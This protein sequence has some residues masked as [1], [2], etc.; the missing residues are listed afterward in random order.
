VWQP[1]TC[2]EDGYGPSLLRL[3]QLTRKVDFAAVFASYPNGMG[4]GGPYPAGVTRLAQAGT[5]CA[6]AGAKAECEAKAMEV[7]KPSNACVMQGACVSFLV[8]TAGDEVT[9][10]EERSALLSLLGPIDKAEKAMLVALYDGAFDGRPFACVLPGAIPA[11]GPGQTLSQTLATGDGFDVQTTWDSCGGGIFTQTV[12]VAADGTLTTDSKTKVGESRCMVGRRP[13]GLRAAACLPQATRLGAFLAGA[14]RLEAASVFAFERLARELGA[15]GAPAE[16]QAE[17]LRSALDEVRHAR[18]M[19]ALARRFGGEL[20]APEVAALPVRSR[21]A[22][23]LENAIEGCVRETYGALLA[24]HQAQTARD[25]ELRAALRGIADDELRH[26]LLAHTVAEW[27]EPQLSASERE[28]LAG[29]RRAALIQ[30][31]AEL[32][33]GLVPAELGLLGWP[34]RAVAAELIQRLGQALGV[35]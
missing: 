33:T 30:L 16:L 23:A 5:Q 17:A 11:L 34:S 10:S 9:R 3:D 6:T 32:D 8:T 14:A 31:V 20:L 4:Q 26:A 22:I 24:E 18:V 13:A 12:H 7:A 2:G 25:P 35:S 27:L 29:A 28:A 1:Y 15:L 21:S 19:G